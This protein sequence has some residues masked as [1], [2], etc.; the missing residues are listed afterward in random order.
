MTDQ[1]TKQAREGIYGGHD[2]V[3]RGKVKRSTR[4][5]KLQKHN[6]KKGRSYQRMHEDQQRRRNNGK[7]VWE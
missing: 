4:E 7:K 6:R 1:A 2:N 5:K 3:K